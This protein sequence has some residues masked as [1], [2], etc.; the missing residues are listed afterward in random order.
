MRYQISGKHIDIGAALQTHVQE[1][2]GAV[3]GKYA[4]RPTDATVFFPKAPPNLS[5]K[6]P[7]IFPPA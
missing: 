7:C 1:E 2:L 3:V 5:V 4:E 6:P